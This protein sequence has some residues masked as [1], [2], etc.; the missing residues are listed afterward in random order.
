MADM[1]AKSGGQAS[2]PAQPTWPDEVYRTLKEAGVRQVGMVP[3]AGH[4]RLIR[5][6]EA[7]PETHFRFAHS[8]HSGLI[9]TGL[10]PAEPRGQFAPAFRRACKRAP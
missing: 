10:V 1:A 2:P 6:F 8:S 4:S 9:C 5:S 3:D 7:D